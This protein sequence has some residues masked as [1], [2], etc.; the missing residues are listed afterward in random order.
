M[1]FTSVVKLFAYLKDHGETYYFRGFN[2]NI[3]LK[4]TLGRDIGFVE[5]EDKLLIEFAKSDVVDNLNIDSIKRL[6]EFAQHYGIPTRLSDWSC[7][8]YVA[9]FFSLGKNI[10]NNKPIFI[11]IINRNIRGKSKWN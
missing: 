7:N 2:Q 11:G 1:I 6:L 8:P 4:P 9:L 3:H 10:L 5:N